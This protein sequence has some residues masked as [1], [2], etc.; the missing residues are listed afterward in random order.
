MGGGRREGFGGE[1]LKGVVLKGV[2]VGSVDTGV[3]GAGGGGETVSV[4]GRR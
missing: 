1:C 2:G 4:V 3:D